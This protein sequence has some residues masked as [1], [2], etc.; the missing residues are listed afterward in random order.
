[1]FVFPTLLAIMLFLHQNWSDWRCFTG[2]ASRWLALS[3]FSAPWCSAILAEFVTLILSRVL[4]FLSS[5]VSRTLKILYSLLLAPKP[6]FKKKKHTP[7][8]IYSRIH[9]PLFIQPN[10]TFRKRLCPCQWAMLLV[11]HVSFFYETIKAGFY[12][13]L[14]R[15]GFCFNSVWGLSLNLSRSRARWMEVHTKPMARGF[16]RISQLVWPMKMNLWWKHIWCT[17]KDMF[18]QQMNPVSELNLLLKS[19]HV[20]WPWKPSLNL[21]EALNSDRE[22]SPSLCLM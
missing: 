10:S 4:K 15:N 17:C 20:C 14:V 2:P 22:K 6:G 21:S 19:I 3:F 8:W 13:K 12:M 18:D 9:S 5:V 16:K 11:P 1:M 7:Q